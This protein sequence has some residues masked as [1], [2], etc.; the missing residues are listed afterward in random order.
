M[1]LEGRWFAMQTDGARTWT[2]PISLG[3]RYF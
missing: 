3:V 2:L 1:F